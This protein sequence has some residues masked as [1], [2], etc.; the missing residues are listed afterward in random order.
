MKKKIKKH[1]QLCDTLIFIIFGGLA[2]LEERTLCK[3]EA[4]GSKP[5]FSNTFKLH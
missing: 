4:P 3:R 5:G 2:Q 1:I